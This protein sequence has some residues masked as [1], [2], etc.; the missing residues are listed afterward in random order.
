L[1]IAADS[2]KKLIRLESGNSYRDP[3]W[4]ARHLD[5]GSCAIKLCRP[6]LYVELRGTDLEIGGLSAEVLLQQVD[7]RDTVPTKLFTFLMAAHL[8][9]TMTL[10]ELC[11]DQG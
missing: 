3:G 7:G 10:K 1:Q 5:S 6:P 2:I 4:L 8:S 9:H 11:H